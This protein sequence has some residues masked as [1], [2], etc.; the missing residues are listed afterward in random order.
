[1]DGARAGLY[2]ENVLR[3]DLRIAWV[4]L[5]LLLVLASCTEQP[6]AT[7]RSS[8]SIR[9]GPTPA[10]S[11]PAPLPTPTDYRSASSLEESVF[12][13]RGDSASAY[14]SQKLPAALMRPLHFP[15]IKLGASCP[16]TSG[17]VVSTVGFSVF[18][19]GKGPVYPGIAGGQLYAWS[20][21]WFGFKTL[22]YVAP[23]YDGPV[24]IRGARIDG[25]GLV[26]FGES[27]FI[28]HLIIPPGPTLNEA[29]DGYRTAPGGTYVTGP[30]CY[31]WQIDG[32]SFS[33]VIVVGVNMRVTNL[34]G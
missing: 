30:G 29:A 1:M 18:A 24:L 16:I 17:H 2:I 13:C 8:P 31:A 4:V 5:P 28:G 10:A 7:A 22:W 23:S 26:G 9:P 12:S 20:G 25:D 19:L 21:G 11:I 27:P 34:A 14:C 6:I 33:D 32:L 3:L 15:K